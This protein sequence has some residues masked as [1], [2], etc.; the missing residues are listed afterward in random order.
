[1]YKNQ[2]L[3]YRQRDNK[4]KITHT[5]RRPQNEDRGLSDY[6]SLRGE[7]IHRPGYSTLNI[8]EH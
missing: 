2:L 7:K 5:R 3:S 4:Y 1:M 6:T 8:T